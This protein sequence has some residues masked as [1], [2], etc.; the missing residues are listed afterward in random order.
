M[1][2]QLF[3]NSWF[4]KLIG[5]VCAWLLAPM[6][7]LMLPSALIV[8]I[9]IGHAFDHWAWREAG[10]PRRRLPQYSDRQRSSLEPHLSFLY[11]ALGAIAKAGGRV[12]AGHIR[13][14]ESI[15]ANMG[16]SKAMQGQA[17]EWFDA[18][19]RGDF[20]FE[21]TARACLA[22]ANA[23]E[24]LRA[25][26]L[27]C[28]CDTVAIA[29]NDLRIE[30]LNEI[31]AIL[32]YTPERVAAELG[33]AI[34]HIAARLG[35]STMKPS[36]LDA[37]TPPTMPDHVRA[38]YYCLD[39]REDASMTSVKRAYRRL[40]SRYHPD[41]LPRDATMVQHEYA[42]TRMVEFRDALETI[43]AHLAPEPPP[44]GDQS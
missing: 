14:A 30:R 26:T 4:G 25:A 18:G 9:A 7:P 3:H 20:D 31:A 5:V 27:A 12:T 13:Y 44:T 36:P 43:E 39:A 38:A 21:A 8:G 37:A 32:G 2:S 29:E 1:Q 15:M 28:M 34:E 40:V 6:D 10:A 19:K 24:E 22:D 11:A 33:V 41:R 17:I 42:Q 35:N 16:F 23:K